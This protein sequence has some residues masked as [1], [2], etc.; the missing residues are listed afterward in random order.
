MYNCAY[1]W[2]DQPKPVSVSVAQLPV[3]PVPAGNA[4]TLTATPTN[5]GT[6][7]TYQWLVNGLN[8]GTNSATYSYYPV[9]GDE[10][11]CIVVS[12]AYCVSG[13]PATS[14]VAIMEVEGIPAAI[15]VTGIVADGKDRCYSA[16]QTLTVAGYGK[17]YI[18]NNGGSSTM[19]AGQNIIYLPGTTVKPGG[20]MHGYITTDSLYCGQKSPSVP[21]VLDVAEE[22]I[23]VSQAVSFRI[24]PNPTSGNFTVE[25]KSA[26]AF[27]HVSIEVYGMRGEKIITGDMT[28]EKKRELSISGFPV[29]VYFVKVV[30]G[31]YVE[32]IKLIKTN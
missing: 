17:T 8:V 28:G 18:V 27:E 10:V 19:I 21:K 22:P 23:M 11:T 16:T 12:N 29:G 13:N 32:T 4:V 14:A 24:F 20:Y 9:N 26:K 5:G 6:T 31:E 7:P 30:A 1:I 25:Q 3:N 2:V 15:T